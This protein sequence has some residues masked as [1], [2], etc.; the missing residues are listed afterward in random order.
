MRSILITVLSYY[1]HHFRSLVPRNSLQEILQFW[2]SSKSPTSNLSRYPPGFSSEITPIPCH[3]HNDYQHR[4]PL[5]EALSAGCRSVEAD[6]WL[7]GSGD[8]LHVGHS[9]NSLTAARTL[10]NLYLDPLSQIL[11]RQNQAP[12]VSGDDSL[13]PA[14]KYGVFD[15]SPSTA[16]TLLIDIKSNGTATFPVLEAHLE[17]LRS[18]GWLT[19]Y[20]GSVVIP[21]LITVVA[22]GNAPFPLLTK[23]TTYRDIFY[24]APLDALSDEGN[25]ANSTLYTAENSYY[26][27]VAF[28]SA[29]GKPWLGTLTTD[30]VWKIRRQI[31]E[32]TDRG[33]KSRYWDTPSWPIGVRDHIWN[34]LEMEGVGILNVDDLE[35][36]SKKKW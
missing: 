17:P 13:A 5:Y 6:V 29:I 32:A 3:S 10:R 9:R 11:T 20:N 4:V 23:N 2:N 36:A 7:L 26:A 16:L 30:Q 31:K 35:S 28:S 22:S 27:S 21:G 12:F 19:H 15:V 14:G 1:V 33:L 8:E 18:R 34:V 24:D 25:P